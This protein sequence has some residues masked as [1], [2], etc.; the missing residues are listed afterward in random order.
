M[1]LLLAAALLVVLPACNGDPDPEPTPTPEP[2]P[3]PS[4]TLRRCTDDPSQLCR[5][6]AETRVDFLGA[7][8]C[9]RPL[10]PGQVPQPLPLMIE[11]ASVDTG[12]VV[13]QEQHTGWPIAIHPDWREYVYGKVGGRTVFFH[14]RL[15]P[16]FGD[17]TAEPEW[18]DVGGAY[19]RVGGKA[20]LASFNPLFWDR[21]Q[22]WAEA[23]C[24][25]G[26]YVEFDLVDRWWAK[27]QD[28]PNPM[29]AEWNVQS[30]SMNLHV[31]RT[32]I[33]PG[34]F[35]DLWLR[36]VVTVLGPLPCVIWQDGNEVG[37]GPYGT[38][39]TFSMRERVR[40]WENA[41][42][43]PV[44]L[45]ATNASKPEAEEGPVDYVTRHQAHPIPAPVYGKP[46]IINEYNPSPAL[47]P[48]ELYR[49]FCQAKA[50]RTEMAYWRHTQ[51]MEQ[52]GTTLQLMSG[53]CEPLE[54]TGCDFN[55]PT[56]A[57]MQVA[58]RTCSV[59]PQREGRKNFGFGVVCDRWPDLPDGT[60]YY[61]QDGLWP[62][63][64]A[65][66]RRDGPVAPP[67]HP[68]RS[69]CESQFLGQPCATFTYES[70]THM[71]FDPWYCITAAGAEFGR[72]EALVLDI[73]CVNQNHPRNVRVC[74]QGQFENH[75]SW[76]RD[77]QG[78]IYE[79]QWAK[80]MAA[81]NGDVC[82]EAAGSLFRSCVGYVEP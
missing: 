8:P 21:V 52:M 82:A 61:C 40:H 73:Q 57:A 78:K 46:S 18:A 29:R 37:L 36:Q 1:R 10:E 3:D 34:S 63:R 44:H 54:P 69:A 77:A 53:G 79:G 35:E 68:Q 48:T 2:T 27:Q 71:S 9:C 60:L 58:G 31:G 6:D 80:A 20:D 13:L 7:I 62:A 75:P 81:G 15:G 19:S 33:R 41:L 59:L 45:F 12:E 55:T 17:H 11:M 39:W 67:G 74:G 42:G 47:A 50:N 76:K 25:E 49:R 16:F 72:E 28:I 56:A 30:Y 26:G 51:T 23:T 14:A 5:L 24:L 38:E 4:M 65:E 66:G 43:T 32:T 22:A 70:D 64:C